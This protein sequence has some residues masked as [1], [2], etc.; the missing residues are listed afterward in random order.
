LRPYL[1]DWF[2]AHPALENW[3]KELV[4]S[5]MVYEEQCLKF[6]NNNGE[7]LDGMAARG[8][9]WVA[10]VSNADMTAVFEAMHTGKPLTADLLRPSAVVLVC[11]GVNS[12]RGYTAD[13]S[14]IDQ[15]SS[16]PFL[17][18]SPLGPRR[19]VDDRSSG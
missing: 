13:V 8:E 14:R 19:R 17:A 5:V 1:V 4:R 11:H 2:A 15:L 6:V 12:Y 3:Q 7:P 16:H 18:K 10:F 9:N